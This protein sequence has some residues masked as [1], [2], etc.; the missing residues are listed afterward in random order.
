MANLTITQLKF[1]NEQ[2]IPL[3]LLF[4]AKGLK[5]KEY[6]EAMKEEGKLFAYGVTPCGKGNHTLRSRN[7]DC[8]QCDTAKIA[9]TLRHYK[10]AYVYIAGSNSNGLL[11]IGSSVKPDIRVAQLGGLQYGDAEDWGILCKVKC[12]HAGLIEFRVHEKLKKY[13][14]PSEYVKQGRV[15]K[16]FELFKCDFKIALESLQSI[17]SKEENDTLSLY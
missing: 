8:I 7:G 16:S 9:Y 11:K 2:E 1:L 15:Q 5:R 6:Q 3:T 10:S 14:F 12:T 13:F 4:D 17:L